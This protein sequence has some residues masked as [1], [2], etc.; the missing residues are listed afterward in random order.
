MERL[1][2]RGHTFQRC[3]SPRHSLCSDIACDRRR[4]A[5]AKAQARYDPPCA[6]L[7]LRSRIRSDVKCVRNRGALG[8]A[9]V[10]ARSM[11]HRSDVRLCDGDSPDFV[12]PSG[13]LQPWLARRPS[14]WRPL[15]ESPTVCP[16]CLS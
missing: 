13:A 12:P 8:S 14:L 6:R 7:A 2:A 15:R 16:Y 9:A 3:R 11:A 4:W 1:R 5:A 10:S